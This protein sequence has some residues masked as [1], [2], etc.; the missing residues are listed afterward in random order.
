[1]GPSVRVQGGVCLQKLDVSV[2]LVGIE[3][4]AESHQAMNG[5]ANRCATRGIHDAAMRMSGGMETE[6][7]AILRKN[8]APFSTGSLHMRDIEG[9]DQARLTHCFDIDASF[10]Q[11]LHNG[12]GNV[13]VE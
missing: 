3:D 1:M 13:F 12:S 9:A 4:L 2:H 6:E 5:L 11:A 7:I 10:A 8:D